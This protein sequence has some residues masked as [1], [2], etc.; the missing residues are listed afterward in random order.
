MAKKR[1]YLG[2]IRRLSDLELRCSIEPEC[3]CW[4]WKQGLTDSGSAL[5]VMYLGGKRKQYTGRRAALIL[6]GVKPALGHEAIPTDACAHADC[7]NPKHAYF[8]TRG[9]RNRVMADRGVWSDPAGYAAAVAWA[10]ANRK[11]DDQQRLEV[12]H[13]EESGVELA[14]RLGVSR[15]CISLIRR[16]ANLRAPASSVFN[17]SGA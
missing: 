15:N 10:R 5:V 9:E 6:S 7:V 13:S 17:W 1:R 14:A 11:L 8:G 2:G 3:G 4:R 12:I 16:R